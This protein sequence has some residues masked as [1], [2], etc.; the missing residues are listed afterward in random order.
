MSTIS[1]TRLLA[2]NIRVPQCVS[3]KHMLELL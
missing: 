3:R 1:R 2:L